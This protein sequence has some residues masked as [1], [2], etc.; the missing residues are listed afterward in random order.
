MSALAKKHDVKGLRISARR[1]IYA[2][3]MDLVSE[4]TESGL[5]VQK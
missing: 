5:V 2:A 4:L 1:R 3:G